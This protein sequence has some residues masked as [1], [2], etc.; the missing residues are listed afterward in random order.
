MTAKPLT[1]SYI[2]THDPEHP[3]QEDLVIYQLF[4]KARKDGV[5]GELLNL[6]TKERWS[7]TEIMNK[8]WFDCFNLQCLAGE[9]IL[10][11]SK[12]KVQSS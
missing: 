6:E 11:F 7:T 1:K 4:E 3:I 10:Q 9:R 12:I 8:V 2:N 5:V